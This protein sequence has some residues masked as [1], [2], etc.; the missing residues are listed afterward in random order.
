[1]SPSSNWEKEISPYCSEVL[2]DIN[3]RVKDVFDILN[4]VDYEQSLSFLSPS[5]KMHENAHVRD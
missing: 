2:D 4:C 5:N 1:M 3:K